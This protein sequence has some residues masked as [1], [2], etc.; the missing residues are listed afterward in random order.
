MSKKK[1]Q[2]VIDE[3]LTKIKEQKIQQLLGIALDVEYWS[4]VITEMGDEDV[5]RKEFASENNK[6]LIGKNGEVLSDERNVSKMEKIQSKIDALVKANE[7]L[8][9]LKQMNVQIRKYMK[10]LDKP[11]DKTKK[12]LEEVV[13]L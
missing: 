3:F 12:A 5:L 7:E 13:L 8:T 10:H 11:S 4:E 6:R 9:R 2:E 1:A